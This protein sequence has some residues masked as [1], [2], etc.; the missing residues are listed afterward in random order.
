MKKL[1]EVILRRADQ[2]V[3]SFRVYVLLLHRISSFLIFL[4]FFELIPI[5]PQQKEPPKKKVEPI[6]H[7]ECNYDNKDHLG[8]NDD[9]LFV[10]GF[11]TSLPRREIKSQLWKH[12]GSCGKVIR[13][14]VPIEC[15]TGASL[16]FVTR[17]SN[18]LQNKKKRKIFDFISLLFTDLLSLI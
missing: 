18:L 2:P 1:H 10:R 17:S 5:G 9:T 4:V 15:E 6:Y 11:D 8:H 12:F 16:G 13:V 3:I 14:Y 7:N